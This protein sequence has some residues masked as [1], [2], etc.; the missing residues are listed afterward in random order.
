MLKNMQ[1]SLRLSSS[2]TPMTSQPRM[3]KALM[4]WQVMLT[5][6]QQWPF[7][8]ISLLACL[9]VQLMWETTCLTMVIGRKAKR[10]DDARK[11]KR[12]IKMEC[13]I[14]M[15]KQLDRPCIMMTWVTDTK[16]KVVEQLNYKTRYALLRTFNSN[17][18]LFTT[19]FTPLIT[20]TFNF[21]L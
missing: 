3:T 15:I 5:H 12:E 10:A 6:R 14:L 7:T 21:N 18:I 4:L 11:R 13:S 2:P 16:V 19:V 1:R 17:H 9:Q 8:T 20:L